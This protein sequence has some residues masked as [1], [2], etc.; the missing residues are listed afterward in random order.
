MSSGWVTLGKLASSFKP[1]L[2]LL[3]NRVQYRFFE[4]R[5][6]HP[7]KALNAIYHGYY[8]YCF[9]PNLRSQHT[10]SEKRMFEQLWVRWKESL[11][12]LQLGLILILALL[13]SIWSW[14]SCFALWSP[15]FSPIN[16]EYEKNILKDPFELPWFYV[17][18]LPEP[19]E[20]CSWTISLRWEKIIRRVTNMVYFGCSGQSPL[21]LAFEM[22]SLW[23]KYA[24]SMTSAC[25]PSKV[26]GCCQQEWGLL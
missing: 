10:W 5:L 6:D 11:Q 26:F 8:S 1:Q 25:W 24:P 7:C 12:G 13:L 18:S 16:W 22:K 21:Y 9:T 19:P 15:V 2:P 4:V 3:L 20:L 23:A 17:L 14:V